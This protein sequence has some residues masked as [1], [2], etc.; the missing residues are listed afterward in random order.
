MWGE[1]SN[2]TVSSSLLVY[3]MPFS[4]TAIVGG[5]NAVD[6]DHCGHFG[7]GCASIR[8]ALDQVKTSESDSLVLSFES[9]A[10]LSESFSFT[11]SQTVSFES[12]SE[13]LQTI[14]VEA[15][16]KLRVSSGKLAL[17]TLSFA[18]TAL[19]FLSSLISMNGGSLSVS[20]CTFTGFSSSESGAIVSGSL[21]SSSS[22]V[23]SGSSFVSCRSSKNGGALSVVC[24]PN[25]PSSS[26]VIKASF[27]SC[28]CGDGQNGD[29]VFVSGR[30]LSKVIVPSNWEATTSGLT[31]PG[32]SSRLWGV[33]S[34]PSGSS[35]ASSTLLVYLI[36]HR[37]GWIFTSSSLGSEEI[38]CG[39]SSTPC[40][41]LSTS[42]S[43]LSSSPSNTLTVTDSSTLDFTL[44]STFLALTITGMS[45]PLKPLSVT[46]TGRFS[47]PSNE[48]SLAHLALSPSTNPFPFTLIS[49]SESGVVSVTSCLF[50]SF[51]LS[52]SP[53]IDHQNGELSLYS[54]SFSNIH[55]SEGSGSCLH[56]ALDGNMKLEVDDVW[57][58]D[59]SVSDGKGDGFFISFP[60]SLTSNV[61]SFTLTNLHFASSPSQSSNTNPHFL[62]LTG[63]NLSSWIGVDDSR[64]SG[65]FEGKDVDAEWLW[66]EDRH[67]DIQLSTSLL[68]YLTA[69]VGPVGVDES[70]YDIAKCGYHSV[71]CLTLP[72]ALAK[73]PSSGSST[74]VVQVRVEINETIAFSS[75]TIISGRAATSQ[76]EVG[77]DA[78]FEVQTID[79]N[80]EVSTLV[81]TLP[82]ELS[83]SC[84]FSASGGSLTFTTV[85]FVSSDPANEYSSQL[86]H[87]TAPL[88]LSNV[89][90]SSASLSDNALIE[91]L[92][93]VLVDGCH[94]SSVSRST[95][96]GSVIEANISETTEMKVTHS[97]FENCKSDSTTNWILLKGLNTLISQVSSWEG[98]LSRSSDRSSVMIESDGH[99]PF[100]LVDILFPPVVSSSVFVGGRGIDD[101]TSCGD[102]SAPGRTIS[103]GFKVGL[104]RPDASETITV[105]LIEHAGFGVCVW[106]GSES[107]LITAGLKRTRLLIEDD[108]EK[109]RDGSGVV[110]VEGGSVTLSGLTLLLP[111][112]A[113]SKT[114]AR[115]VSLVFGSGTVLFS[116]VLISQS[117]SQNVDLGLCWIVGGSLS[118]DQV[119]ISQ[120]E[121][122]EDACLIVAA[123]ETK[124]LQCLIQHSA[125]TQTTS[126][127]SP[128]LVF[129]SSS[130]FSQFQVLG[131]TFSHSTT[132][133]TATQTG[134]TAS[135]VA[136]STNQ[137]ELSMKD[138][139]FEEC[140]T[141]PSSSVA[142]IIHVTV[143]PHHSQRVCSIRVIRCNFLSSQ[144]ASL[145]TSFIHF[146]LHSPHACVLFE[147]SL[148]SESIQTN[149]KTGVL[150]EYSTGLPIVTRRRTVFKHCAVVLSGIVERSSIQHNLLYDD[151]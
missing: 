146:T 65:S 34:S 109:D 1:D 19:T 5:S 45:S 135:L 43:R 113:S 101:L 70:G 31:Q 93:D 139:T 141:T 49:I 126:N 124:P 39:E 142:S 14:T 76:L 11:T 114:T 48:L 51:T 52:N 10:T 37:S 121:M 108:L 98:T 23:V 68:F 110:N 144:S 125:I 44:T 60:S 77:E 71:W 30:E 64:F 12:S 7:V 20:K 22:L 42:F 35:L 133:Q 32:D 2:T 38:G 103:I 81:I 94:F 115:P 116:N 87:S 132:S 56:S 105:S 21:G 127:N 92:S 58:D 8:N 69:H 15:Q 151:L 107:L 82:S 149:T 83:S 134:P 61:A 120:L 117:S 75:S 53:L 80:I 89:N 3:L 62:F 106:V 4:D 97:T 24:A 131:C 17:N 74:V 55:R 96:L 136:I 40:R 26:L 137:T 29:W 6:I 148:F 122:S 67:A 36:G 104:T 118:I 57:M 88:S 16:G 95:G 140:S 86:I 78:H 138:A 129:S 18:T 85:S 47:I 128:L 100:S 59:V 90:V 33:D 50:S 25:T 91:S 130:P 143:F 119:Q 66:T 9:G 73:L 28:L 145:P 123:S 13:S 99:E 27:S 102:E 79:V 84:M 72:L 46:S 150:I 111:T 41:T 147:D 54:S 63:F 112:F